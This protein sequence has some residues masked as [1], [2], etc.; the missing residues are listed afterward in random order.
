M[1][2]VKTL[3]VG[4]EYSL[5]ELGGGDIPVLQVALSWDN[6][7]KQGLI[8]RLLNKTT[9]TDLDLCCLVYDK[10]GNRIDQ[11]WYAKLASDDK[12]ILHKGD[13]TT[14]VDDGDDESLSIDLYK[15]SPE[16]HH[17]VLCTGALAK[18]NDLGD[19]IN[20]YMH[21]R[22]SRSRRPIADYHVRRTQG[23]SLQLMVHLIR[24]DEKGWIVKPLGY[25]GDGVTIQ[26][27]YGLCRREVINKLQDNNEAA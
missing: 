13:N 19:V 22:D 7:A 1:S 8:N 5:N 21:L 9:E 18:Q 2:M 11:I 27:L 12:A 15:L 20:T 26:D 23:S 17:I 4:Y 10:D 3:K 16:A 24:S 25:C 14:G 6:R